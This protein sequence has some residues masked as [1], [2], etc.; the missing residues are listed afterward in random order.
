[1]TNIKKNDAIAF[2]IAISMLIFALRG[3]FG[4]AVISLYVVILLFFLLK[5]AK[6]KFRRIEFLMGTFLLI[7]AVILHLCRS[8]SFEYYLFVGY[9]AA[10][11]ILTNSNL[12][13]YRKLWES[14]KLIAIFEA[15]GI[16]LQRFIPSLYYTFISFILPENVV[17][18]I[19]SRL[20]SGYCTGFSRE[21]SYTMFLIVIGLGLFIFNVGKEPEINSSIDRWRRWLIVIFLFGALF[22]SGKRATLVF[23]VLSI[24]IVNFIVSRSKLK[25]L[26]YIA[27]GFFGIALVYFTFP[28]WSKIE[29]LQRVVELLKFISTKDLIG[30]TNG[31]NII[32]ETAISLWKSNK[33]FGIG[34]GNFKYSMSDNLWFSGYDV[35]NCYLQVLCETGI[36]GAVI[37]YLLTIAAIV[38]LVKCIHISHKQMKAHGNLAAFVG[39]IQLFF[40]MYCMTEPILYEYTDYIIYFICINVSS[41]IIKE[42]KKCYTYK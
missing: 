32:Y 10:V 24:F 35:H 28:L 4:A 7:F 3:K 5:K 6:I 30:I 27:I 1:M 8:L 19:K 42:Y 33:W 16:Y 11:L 36:I 29:A 38:N 2:L 39:Y 15:F 34:W 26:K 21:I 23:F 41:L 14:L 20:I 31:R 22:I 12:E 18:S 40:I 17:S 25:L 37:Y 9:F 13:L